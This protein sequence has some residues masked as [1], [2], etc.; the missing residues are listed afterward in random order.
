MTEETAL[1]VQNPEH[2]FLYARNRQEMISAQERLAEWLV[3]KLSEIRNQRQE[4][5]RAIDTAVR[6]KWAVSPYR[7]QDSFLKRS[8]EYYE[9]VLAAV[10][11]GYTIIPS[12]WMDCF[13]IRVKRQNASQIRTQGSEYSTPSIPD[14][15]TDAPPL[16]EGRYVSKESAGYSSS[17]TEPKDGKQIKKYYSAA[18]D[19]KDFEFPIM[20]A[21]VELMESTAA[22]MALKCFDELGVAPS[23]RGKDPLIIGT[24]KG[25]RN[26]ECRFLIAWYLDTRAL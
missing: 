2:I 12:F 24:V 4:L 8:V 1:A 7:S 25:P 6:N 9:K 11:A 18:T 26:K 10:R 16:G 5:N 13:A 19:F 23:R 3:V 17:F 14:Q 20:A 21:K 15:R 22:A